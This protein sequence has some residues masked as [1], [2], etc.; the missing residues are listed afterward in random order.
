MPLDLALLI[1]SVI[2]AGSVAVVAAEPAREAQSP[3]SLDYAIVVTGGEL[4]EGAYPDGHTHFLTRT[5]RPLGG[6]CVASLTVDDN[7]ED[8]FKALSFATNHAPVVLVTGGLGPTP[9]DITRETL[10]EFT[11]IPLRESEEALAELERRFRTSRDQLRPNLRRQ[12]LV[13]A[14]GTFLKNPAGT[15]VGLVFDLPATT[16]IALPG[17]PK[18]LQPMVREELAP[19]LR[20]RFGVREFGATLT[21]RFVGVGQSQ[22]DQT[23]K[24]HVTI[25]PDVTVTSLFEGSRVDFTFT[26]PGHTPEDAARLR[27]LAENIREH[28]GDYCYAD[29]GSTLE[30]VVGRAGLARGD[31]LTLVEIGSGGQLA[32]ALGGVPDARQWLAGA[33]AAPT[34]EAMARLLALPA[35]LQGKTGEECVKTMTAAGARLAGSRLALG[36]GPVET[37]SAGTRGVWVA[38]RLPADRWE[39]RRFPV[40]STGEINSA[41][42]TTPILEQL[43]RWLK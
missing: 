37:D 35:D 12:T 41:N 3:R 5:L 14:R 6:R 33:L 18:E 20:Q 15:A 19:L 31:A 39:T 26:V 21:L 13:P 43:R 27:R 36:V 29:D 34:A 40:Q 28:L 11:G 38:L 10:A 7:R 32:A 24:D 30:A 17:P 4:L 25:A 1:R 16:I 8:I 2:L 9:N 42:L 22:I 23:I